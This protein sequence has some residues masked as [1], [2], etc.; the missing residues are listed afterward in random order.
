MPTPVTRD[1]IV[2]SQGF[3]A[4]QIQ[5]AQLVGQRPCVG[6]VYPH[7]WRMDNELLIHRQIERHVQALDKA[8][9]AIGIT[10]KVGLR[11]PCHQVMDALLTG[12]DGGDAQEKQVATR[13]EG[14]RERTGG[15]HLVHRYRSIGQRVLAQLADKG[16]IHRAE[17][18]TGLTGYLACQ[19][20]L[21]HMLLTIDE[22][23]RH[24]FLKLL[25]C[26]KQASGRVLST[27]E[28]YQSGFFVHICL[29]DFFYFQ[30]V[31]GDMLVVH[32]AAVGTL[33]VVHHTDG[34]RQDNYFVERLEDDLHQH[35]L[36]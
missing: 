31:I 17:L 9:T 13:H 20:H 12:Y 6:L 28:Y 16:D 24:D 33:D 8:I 14:V 22:A 34:H 7:Q 11:Y 3:M 4:Y 27:T 35:H 32:I 18:Y 30:Y 21:F 29:S 2:A 5:H 23:Q 19:F 1:A 15:L 25:L 26:P 10:A 36:S